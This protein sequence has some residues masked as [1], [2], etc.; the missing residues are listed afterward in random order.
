MR[1][2][3]RRLRAAMDLFA[4][5]LPARATELRQ[6]LK[7][8]AGALGRVRDLDVQL[9]RVAQMATW[10]ARWEE[11][12]GGAFDELRALLHSERE[13]ARRHLLADLDSARWERL[14]ADLVA[15]ARR[16]PDRRD[17]ASGMPAALVAGDLV[18]AHH[19]RAVRASR[20]AQ[21]TGRAQEF[22]KLRIR[23]KKLRYSLEFTAPLFGRP[24]RRFI[25]K[26]AK[27]QDALGLLQDAEVGR[28]R[29]RTL[30]TEAADRLPPAT[31]FAMGGIAEHYANESEERR[32]A[33]PTRLSVLNGRAWDELA[34]AIG[35][36]QARAGTGRPARRPH[37][38]TAAVRASEESEESEEE[39][40]PLSRR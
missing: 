30:A 34:S 22:H 28:A 8:L 16:G 26:L 11:P 9:E 38:T 31:L 10:A 33:M 24:A 5:A 18:L 14:A 15:L 17:P 29:L 37:V 6:E 13:D 25:R 23:C 32:R 2:A 36:R 7:W 19:R 12:S 40:G 20:R 27:L 3:T 39:E 35:R 4:D 21:E 1:V